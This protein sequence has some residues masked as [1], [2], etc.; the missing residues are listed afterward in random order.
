MCSKENIAIIERAKKVLDR[1]AVW[2]YSP[3]LSFLLLE[4]LV[5]NMEFLVSLNSNSETV[6]RKIDCYNMKIN[7]LINA[8]C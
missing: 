7:D 8:P 4:A 6:L 2:G 1:E 3:S 5:S